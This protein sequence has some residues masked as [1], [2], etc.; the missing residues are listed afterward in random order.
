MITGR[1][2]FSAASLFAARLER[3]TDATFVGEPMGGSPNLYGNPATWSCRSRGST[4]SVAT[5]YEVGSTRDDPRLTIEP[6]VPVGL[7]FGRL[8]RR[9]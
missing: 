8:L 7:A 4:S 2:T 6:D 1:N 9:A 5:S 3:T